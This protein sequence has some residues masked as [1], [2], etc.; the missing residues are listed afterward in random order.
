MS[1]YATTLHSAR[2]STSS[3]QLIKRKIFT[4]T[5]VTSLSAVKKE[6]KRSGGGG[7]GG[8]GREETLN[9]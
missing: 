3:A 4:A 9:E 2:F 7:G 5:A 6:T 1:K 8:G